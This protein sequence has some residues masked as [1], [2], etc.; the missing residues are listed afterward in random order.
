MLLV[1]ELFYGGLR[2]HGPCVLYSREAETIDHLFVQCA[3]IREVW[4]KV[5]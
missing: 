1:R 3:F 2:N 4:F 5:L